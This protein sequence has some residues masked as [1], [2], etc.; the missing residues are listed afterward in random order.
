MI[1]WHA[2]HRGSC[3]S[4]RETAVCFRGENLRKAISSER[5]QP[6]TSNFVRETLAMVDRGI[7]MLTKAHVLWQVSKKLVLYA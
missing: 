6:T 7:S 2:A 4:R 1:R 5:K 3:P